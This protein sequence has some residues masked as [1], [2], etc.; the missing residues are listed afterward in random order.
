MRTQSITVTSC[1]WDLQTC[2]YGCSHISS[3]LELC[4]RVTYYTNHSHNAVLSGNT[5]TGQLLIQTIPKMQCPQ[6][7]LSHGGGGL[8]IKTAKIALWYLTPHNLAQSSQWCNHPKCNFLKIHYSIQSSLSTN[9]PG[10]DVW[11]SG[12]PRPLKSNWLMLCDLPN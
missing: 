2:R 9:S 8:S 12:N 4:L 7:T 11:S 10:F 1:L 5:V 3:Y 6:E